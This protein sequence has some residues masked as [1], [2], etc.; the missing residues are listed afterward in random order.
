MICRRVS[1]SQH[2]TEWQ[3]IPSLLL[4][5]LRDPEDKP[6][7]IVQNVGIMYLS[8]DTAKHPRRLQSSA[9]LLWEPQNPHKVILQFTWKA[10]IIYFC[11][12]LNST[13]SHIY[14]LFHQTTLMHNFLYSLTI[15][16]Y[17]IIL[18]MFRALT[19]PSS[20]HRLTAVLTGVLCSRLQRATIPDAVRLQFVL[21]KMGMLMLET[22][23]G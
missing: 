16:C 2:F 10:L 14:E 6:T 17:T 22:C 23:R 20:V 1:T 11:A 21:L 3:S 18:D 8:D 9:T 4:L 5:L 7:T 13:E 19:C 12:I 15:L